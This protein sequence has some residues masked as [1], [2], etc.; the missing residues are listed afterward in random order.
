MYKA[1]FTHLLS[2]IFHQNAVNTIEAAAKEIFCPFRQ[3]ELADRD[4][5]NFKDPD[6]NEDDEALGEINMFQ[7]I[8]N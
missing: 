3:A 1:L 2:I 7:V 5:T 8:Q 4:V 6:S